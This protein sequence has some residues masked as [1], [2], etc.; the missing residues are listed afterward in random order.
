MHYIYILCIILRKIL[1]PCFNIFISSDRDEGIFGEMT[2]SD[3]NNDRLPKKVFIEK[4]ISNVFHE[5]RINLMYTIIHIN[6][7]TLFNIYKY[8]L[9]QAVE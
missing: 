6:L 2:F 4:Q 9:W 1:N 8:R 3:I 7:Y 5:F